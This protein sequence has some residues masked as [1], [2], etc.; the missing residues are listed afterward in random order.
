[1]GVGAGVAVVATA[2]DGTIDL[3]DLD[4]KIEQYPDRIA[5]MMITYPSTHGVYESDVR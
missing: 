1:M 4:A 2:D 5:A 3:A